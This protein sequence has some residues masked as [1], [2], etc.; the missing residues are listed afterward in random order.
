MGRRVTAVTVSRV[1]TAP[2]RDS[3]SPGPRPPRVAV[4]GRGVLGDAVRAALVR[5]G[6][7]A[8]LLSRSDGVDVTA[9]FSLAPY[10]AFDAVVEATNVST[11]SAH[12]SR[13]F[14]VA[15]TRNVARA[16]EEAGVPLH[17]LVSIV[18]VAG[19]AASSG[20][21]YAGKAAQE[22]A[23]ASQ[24]RHGT[25]TALLRTTLWY[26][27]ARQNLDRMSV[28]PVGLVPRMTVRPCAVD[29]V[30][31][32]VADRCLGQRTFAELDVC[33]PAVVTLARMTRALRRRPAVLVP[34]PVPGATGRAMR[35][36][37]LLPP[38]GT[39]VV[40]PSFEEWLAAASR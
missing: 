6:A 20:G 39:E 24:Q 9:P 33:G 32:V 16:A 36:G 28:G 17:V 29:A 25:A 27:F 21:Y 11:Q 37:S 31:Q 38:D 14:F 3:S 26:E 18:G 10:G 23:F 30:A 40:G 13:S 7:A 19:P 2:P 5:R 1:T 4:I 8:V 35:D 22:R 34:V 12:A 15:S